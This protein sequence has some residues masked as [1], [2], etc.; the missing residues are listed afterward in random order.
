MERTH[1]IQFCLSG[2]L[3]VLCCSF[4]APITENEFQIQGKLTNIPDGTVIELWITNGDQQEEFD[5]DTVVNGEF[6]FREIIESGPKEFYLMSSD[7]GFPGTGICVWIAPGHVI[8]V[9]GSDKLLKTWTVESDIPEQAVE[10]IFQQAALPELADLVKYN[11]EEHALI[12]GLYNEHSGDKAY[13]DKAWAEIAS[14]R[15]QKAP[16]QQIICE[17]ELEC[18][19]KTPVSPVWMKV[20]LTH[21]ERL[22]DLSENTYTQEIRDLYTRLSE[23]DKK[24]ELGKSIY[25]FMNKP[26]YLEVGDRMVDADLYDLEGNI[27]H[28]SE[29]KG[30][31]IMLD[32]WSK[33]CVP[34]IKSIPEMNEVAKLYKNKLA[35][36]CI[37][38]DLKEDW[39]STVTERKMTGNQW[40]QLFGG[41]RDLYN[42]YQGQ[43]VPHYV[44]I[45]PEG[46]I[47]A[48]WTGYGT[49]SLKVRLA[50]WIK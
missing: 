38:C 41:S 13:E 17:K 2:L 32:F 14:I 18:L 23:A 29:F 33:S 49:G 12:K 24:T 35:I 44:L 6:S 11:I 42:R 15:K 5:C 30:K 50:D 21:V 40:N 27:R 48:M 43:G 16:L 19:K 7:E 1:F 10:N 45:S 3:T 20:Y 37:S 31:Y 9:S 36:V 22:N 25:K 39:I 28:L 8:K 34:C 47:D 26:V 46:I 4:Q